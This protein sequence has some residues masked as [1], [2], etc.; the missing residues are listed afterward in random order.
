[1][2]D[3]PDAIIDILR[4]EARR[5]GRSIAGLARATGCS[6]AHLSRMLAGQESP[7]LS[8]LERIA[9]ALGLHV[10]VSRFEQNCENRENRE[11]RET[12]SATATQ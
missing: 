5:Q 12:Q 1:M 11:N 4:A 8:R 7:T 10:T 9:T 6:R 3:T 2:T